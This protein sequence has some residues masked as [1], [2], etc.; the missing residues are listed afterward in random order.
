MPLLSDALRKTP[1]IMSKTLFAKE[2]ISRKRI[3]D[4]LHVGWLMEGLTMHPTTAR[5]VE[6]FDL[7]VL[8]GTQPQ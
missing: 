7:L 5:L 4:M 2:R 6:G 3:R 8:S 1:H